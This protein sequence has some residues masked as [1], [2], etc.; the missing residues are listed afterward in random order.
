[1]DD[2]TSNT[3]SKTFTDVLPGTYTVTE[4][5]VPN[6]TLSGISCGEG[7]TTR[8]SGSELTLVVAPGANITC[9]FVNERGEVLGAVTPPALVNTGESPIISWIV[10]GTAIM[11]S[12]G[13]V[14]LTKRQATKTSGSN[15]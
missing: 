10:A 7:V 13:A 9:T 8:V 4:A 5:N 15:Y 1:M 2:G 3:S 12:L 11:L 6:W 14:V